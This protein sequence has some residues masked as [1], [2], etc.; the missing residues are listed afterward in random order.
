MW[1]KTGRLLGLSVVLGAAGTLCAAADGGQRIDEN[2]GAASNEVYFGTFYKPVCDKVVAGFEA[3]T[4]RSYPQWER[5]NHAGI[6]ALEADP[7]FQ[8]KRREALVPPPAELAD[9]KSRELNVT[10]ERLGNLFEAALPAD[11]RFNAPAR[12][13]QTFQRALHDGQRDVVRECL[14]GEA[15][16]TL[17]A[18]LEAMTDEQLRRMGDSVA[19]LKLMEAN[20][21]AWQEAI[22]VQRNGAVGRIAF[23]KNGA[24]WKIAQM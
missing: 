23:I 19:E 5:R 7:Q 4:A 21:A 2:A 14:M 3:G 24:N 18:P 1:Q 12:T 6:A 8:A 15:R 13:W 11:V 9:A 17:A 22:V 10:C 20:G 16:K